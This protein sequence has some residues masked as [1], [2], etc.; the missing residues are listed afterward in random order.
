MRR[1][2]AS[3]LVLLTLAAASLPSTA[4]PITVPS[5]LN[6]GDQ[7]RLALT[8]STTRTGD[9]ADIEDYNAFVTAVANSVP[10]LLA[11]GT[12][13]KAIASTASVDARDN[14]STNPFVAT[15]VPIYALD[16]SQIAASNAD[17]WDGAIINPID[18]DES[19]N[20]ITVLV[21]AGTQTTG[22]GFG[23]QAL[24]PGISIHGYSGS[25][26]DNWIAAT[27]GQTDFPYSLYALSDVLTVVPEPGSMA[28]SAYGLAA[29]LA[30]HWL[31][32]T[33]ARRA[34]G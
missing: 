19:G 12:T 20:S 26:D 4:A 9:S 15:G 33:Q 1:I 10:D 5:G 13:W 3:L 23:L 18:A 11:L 8:T 2:L 28:L 32:R 29:L 17:L 7:Y 30:C 34:A 27:S 25:T 14:T 6:P 16:D 21:W 22:E 31:R 24:G